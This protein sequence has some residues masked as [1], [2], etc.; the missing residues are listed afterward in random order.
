MESIG[1][2]LLEEGGFSRGEDGYDRNGP[3]RKLLHWGFYPIA[4]KLNEHSPKTLHMRK[5]LLIAWM[6]AHFISH[7]VSNF[8]KYLERFGLGV[9]DGDETLLGERSNVFLPPPLRYGGWNMSVP[10]PP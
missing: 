2:S 1:I 4:Y 7:D 8:P 3:Q 10:S 6:G 9:V 5:K